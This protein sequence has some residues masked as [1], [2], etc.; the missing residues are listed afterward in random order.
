MRL[1]R[2]A[3]RLLP[4]LVGWVAE[5]LI[6]LGLM[7]LALWVLTGIFSFGA[8][9]HVGFAEFVGGLALDVN[10]RPIGPRF[11]GGLGTSFKLVLGSL[12]IS[13]PLSA[14]VGW[15][16]AR[17]ASWG[18]LRL[19]LALV[20]AT[21]VFI[22]GYAAQ[23]YSNHI[24]FPIVALAF[25]DITVGFMCSQIY[26]E[27]RRELHLPYVRTALAKG[28]GVL[29]HCWRPL[30]VAVLDAIRPRL[31]FLLG[32]TVVV[33]HIF[34]LTPR[35]LGS[36]AIKA[37]GDQKVDLNFLIWVCVFSVAV[38]RVWDLVCRIAREF[39][40]PVSHRD[41]SEEDTTSPV[42]AMWRSV[43][44]APRSGLRAA[45]QAL[46][47]LGVG[48]QVEIEM[49]LLPGA[50]RRGFWRMWLSDWGRG[51][52][53]KAQRLH[54][55]C[56]RS[57]L[58]KV[59]ACVALV[60]CALFLACVAV[61]LSG[62]QP[63]KLE[64]MPSRALKLPGENFPLGTDG[65]GC[66]V[67][68]SIV[69]A[70]RDF[71]YPGIIAVSVPILL[72]TFAGAFAGYCRRGVL[73]TVLNQA[74]DTLDAVPKLIVAIAACVVIDTKGYLYKLLP[75]I[76]FTFT[77]LVFYRVRYV[78][79]FLCQ[80]K[81]VEA[82]RVLGA[83]HARTLLLHLLYNNCK[84]I[85]L[86]QGAFIM[87]H[88]VLLDATLGFLVFSQPDFYTLGALIHNAISDR[89]GA[90]LWNH[91]SLTAP[92]AA[93]VMLISAFLLA[94]DGLRIMLEHSRGSTTQ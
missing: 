17:R 18:L 26:N 80:N 21:P 30:A 33:E 1:R 38:V 91:W 75:V 23:R 44:E 85:V 54:A 8:T 84:S 88:V 29:S 57:F 72:G 58:A 59:K 67:L 32:S 62:W 69:K 10:G 11:V 89:P 82:T 71:V 9:R 49:G 46:R 24:V 12:C 52:A 47:R 40:M 25:G 19:L 22:I 90:G 79:E 74:M 86:V 4:I 27:M 43:C 63:N 61:C 87:G 13:L 76:G 55:Y 92:M 50:R 48:G 15:A 16:A 28:A 64:S 36:M 31:P 77:P 78:V 70:G 94:S 37:V 20:S 35:G 3:A 81:F 14:L 6:A 73:K 2:L 83:S 65:E 7:A 5:C 68:T 45:Q 42:Q 66:C 56:R 41:L 53:Q 34:T 93:T 39:L 60:V 51:W